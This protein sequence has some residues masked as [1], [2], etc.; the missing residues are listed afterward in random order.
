MSPASTVRNPATADGVLQLLD[1]QRHVPEP[2]GQVRILQ[3]KE[4][5]ILFEDGVLHAFHACKLATTHRKVN[6]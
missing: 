4:L 5:D 2:A 3:V 1:R 6:P